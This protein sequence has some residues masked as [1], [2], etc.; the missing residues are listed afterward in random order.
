MSL[1]A[2][3]IVLLAAA[4]FTAAGTTSSHARLRA[5]TD[6]TTYLG[7]AALI[8]LALWVINNYPNAVS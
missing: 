4:G 5:T 1:T 6:Y 8:P 7:G 3:V 2:L